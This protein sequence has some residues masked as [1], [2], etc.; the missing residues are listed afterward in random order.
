MTRPIVSFHHVTIEGDE[1]PALCLSRKAFDK[2]NRVLIP[3]NLAHVF[4]S[5]SDNVSGEAIMER[6]QNYCDVLYGVGCYTP[7]EQK[8]VGD[9]ILSNLDKLLSMPPK[10]P[11]KGKVEKEIERSGLKLRVND[12]TILDAS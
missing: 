9:L 11:E 4:C 7:W 1:Q 5:E 10:M 12:E 6:T 2:W 8:A 3:L